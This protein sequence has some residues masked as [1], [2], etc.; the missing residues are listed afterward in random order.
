MIMIRINDSEDLGFL[1]KMNKYTL[2]QVAEKFGVHPTYISHIEKGKRT[3]TAD[4][5]HRFAQLY[6]VDLETVYKLYRNAKDKQ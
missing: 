5:Q 6:K 2:K 1:R 4:M 3:L